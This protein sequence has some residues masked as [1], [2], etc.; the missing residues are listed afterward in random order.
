[1]ALNL[2]DETSDRR[3]LSTDPMPVNQQR[4]WP[5]RCLGVRDPFR[6]GSSSTAHPIDQG[7]RSTSRAMERVV[8]RSRN[9]LHLLPKN[10]LSFPY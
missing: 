2:A 9:L 6:G 1:V 8:G 7:P 4:V 5:A 10:G 3:A